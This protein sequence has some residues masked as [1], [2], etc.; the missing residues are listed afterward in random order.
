MFA[1]PFF[2]FC[3]WHEWAKATGGIDIPMGLQYHGQYEGD[4]HMNTMS[5]QFLTV[6][7]AARQIGKGKMTLYRWIRAGKIS[8]VTFGGFLFVPRGEVERLKNQAAP[9]KGGN[10]GTDK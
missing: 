3:S 4:S 5:D 8:T 1:L 2:L 9:A 10:D 7:A 6:P